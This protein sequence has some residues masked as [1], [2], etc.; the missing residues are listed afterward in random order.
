MPATVKKS[1]PLKGA[2][3]HYVA[4]Q[5]CTYVQSPHSEVF[6]VGA[7]CAFILTAKAPLPADHTTPV[8]NLLATCLTQDRSSPAAVGPPDQHPPLCARTR[9]ERRPLWM[10]QSPASSG[11]APSSAGVS[12][13][14]PSGAPSASGTGSSPGGCHKGV[15]HP[16]GVAISF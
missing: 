6:S 16:D 4:P 8:C 7:P 15:S 14:P 5:D 13:L 9:R 10:R 11:R 2:P 1:S 12:V 3:H